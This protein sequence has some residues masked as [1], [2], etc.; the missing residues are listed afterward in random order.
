[1]VTQN[2]GG[3]NGAQ[4]PAPPG[5]C[6]KRSNPARGQSMRNEAQDHICPGCVRPSDDAGHGVV[7]T[8]STAQILHWRH[9]FLKWQYLSKHGAQ[10][11]CKHA[12]E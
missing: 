4:L 7:G 8:G 10:Y 2:G 3:V 9:F 6:T 5:N 1:M 12:N 11:A